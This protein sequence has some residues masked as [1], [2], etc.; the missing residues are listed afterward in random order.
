MMRYLKKCEEFSMCSEVGESD[1]LFTELSEDRST[2]YQIV[3]KGSGKIAKVFDSK[4]TKLDETT[5]N[6]VDLKQYKG[7]HT[8]FQSYKPFHIYGF[9]SLKCSDNWDGKLVTN[10][11][12]GDKK[13]WLIC[14]K[15][16]PVVNGVTMKTMDYAKLCDKNYDVVL[17]NGIIGLF[18][19]HS[20]I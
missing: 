6:F 11:F 12:K 15:G 9:N 8:I 7:Y 4:F 17:N 14:F 1:L 20:M 18:T 13:S 3:V 19:K 10:S 5:D 2:L 16:E